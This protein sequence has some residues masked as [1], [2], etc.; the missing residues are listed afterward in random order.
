MKKLNFIFNLAFIVLFFAYI[1]YSNLNRPRIYVIYSFTESYDWE[2]NIDIGLEKFFKK[3]INY[4]VRKFYLRTQFTSDEK[5]E[6]LMANKA[7]HLIKQWNPDLVVL[8]DD[9]AQKL[10]GEQLINNPKIKVVFVSVAAP[11]KDYNYENAKNI[12]G[13]KQVLPLTPFEAMVDKIVPNRPKTFTYIY[14]DEYSSLVFL[15]QIKNYKWNEIEIVDYVKCSNLNELSAAVKKAEKNSSYLLVSI[16]SSIKKDDSSKL[17]LSTEDTNDWIL[18]NSKIPLLSLS[19]NMGVIT[20]ANSPLEQGLSA[21]E[22]IEKITTYNDPINKIPIKTSK[23]FSI[24]INE[25]KC[26]E[27]DINLPDIYFN[28]SHMTEQ[29]LNN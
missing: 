4:L 7:M 29:I 14:D 13:V 12:T 6:E 23:W 9:K 19:E 1:A 5:N 3:H 28:F 2:K 16:L 8:V 18:K 21:G 10:I 24:I 25:K 26:K 11:L 20:I 27:Y 22:M 17:Y 15:E